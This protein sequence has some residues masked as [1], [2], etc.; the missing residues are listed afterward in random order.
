MPPLDTDD[1]PG[2][3]DPA[4]RSEGSLVYAVSDRTHRDCLTRATVRY[5]ADGTIAG[6]D[7]APVD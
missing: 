6:I 1:A 2:I 5:A 3:P 7:R 4:F